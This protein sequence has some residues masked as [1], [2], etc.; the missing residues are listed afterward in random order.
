MTQSNLWSPS[1]IAPAETDE[2]DTP[3]RRGRIPQS[4]WPDILERYRGGATLS[5]LA[6]EFNCTP[7]AIS[8]IVRKAEASVGGPEGEAEA[9]PATPAAAVETV[10][11][12]PAPAPAPVQTAPAAEAPRQQPAAQPAPTAAPPARAPQ[13]EGRAAPDGRPRDARANEGR[14]NEARPQDARGPEGRGQEGR[15]T[16][17]RS[18]EGRPQD[19][20]QGDGGRGDNRFEPR[21]PRGDRPRL[22][23]RSTEPGQDRG[24][25]GGGPFGDPRRGS[26]Q[27][28]GPRPLQLNPQPQGAPQ[29]A[30][31]PPAGTGEQPYYRH[32][33]RSPAREEAAEVP[34]A[35]A[36]QRMAEAAQGAAEAY[37]RWRA[38]PGEVPMQ[39]LTDA[40]HELRKVIARME[41]E[42]SA[43]RKDEHAA[44][45]IPIPTHRAAQRS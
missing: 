14:H 11:P 28:Q 9:T 16:D 5:A 7:S 41:I 42:M 31:L 17:G 22:G 19:G 18:Q 13:A 44:R 3:K 30:P 23:I 34:S 15:S 10:A 40:L 37:R 38:G 12:P 26:Q 33:Q 32:Q 4:A 29:P 45:P 2:A 20:R 36:D 43:T 24:D 25:R 6:R 39:S 21:E 35:P 1:D 8:Y 27:P